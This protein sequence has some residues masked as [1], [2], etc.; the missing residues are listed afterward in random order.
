VSCIPL[1]VPE[2]YVDMENKSRGHHI[3]QEIHQKSISETLVSVSDGLRSLRAQHSARLETPRRSNL[4]GGLEKGD[5]VNAAAPSLLQPLEL[6]GCQ[7]DPNEN[8]APESLSWVFNKPQIEEEQAAR[9]NQWL[10]ADQGE[11]LR[12]VQGKAGSGKTTLMK[13]IYMPEVTLS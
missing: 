2:N 11:S 7:P 1:D 13:H 12:W 9:L 6:A 5:C 3:A 8:I 4:D 10:S